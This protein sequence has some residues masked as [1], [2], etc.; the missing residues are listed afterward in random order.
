VHEAIKERCGEVLWHVMRAAQR[1]EPENPTWRRLAELMT[2]HF[3]RLKPVKAG[4]L[5]DDRRFCVETG[6]IGQHPASR[7]QRRW[8]RPTRTE[9]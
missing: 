4:I 8:L 6:F 7:I 5:P 9:S 1:V 3:K 2:D